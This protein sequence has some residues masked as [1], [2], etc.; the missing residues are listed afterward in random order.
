MNKCNVYVACFD[1]ALNKISQRGQMD[2]VVRFWDASRNV[3]STSYL[4]STF[5]GHATAGDLEQKF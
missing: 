4:N 1:E 3:V 5:L 2:I